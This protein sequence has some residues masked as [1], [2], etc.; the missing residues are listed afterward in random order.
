MPTLR[1]LL[2]VALC[3]PGYAAAVAPAA[4]AVPGPTSTQAAEVTQ[5]SAR[6]LAGL[7]P[8]GAHGREISRTR[9]WGTHAAAMESAWTRKRQRALDP[10][11]G[12]SEREV[13]TLDGSH[14]AL[15][16][17]FSGPDFMYAHTLF[18]R[19]PRYLLVGLEDPGMAPAWHRMDESQAA[20]SLAQLRQSTATLMQLSFFRTNSMKEDFKR[21]QLKGVAPVLMAMAARSGFE[22]RAVDAVHLDDAGSLCLGAADKSGIGGV[23]L[24]L[25]EAGATATRELVYLKVDLSD[26]ALARTPQFERHVRA[27]GAGPVFLKAASYLMHRA[28]FSV[29]RNLVLE[30]ARLVLQDDS[31][32]PYRAYSP[33]EWDRRLYGAYA[34]PI[35]LFKDRQQAALREAYARNAR[36]LD[37]GIGYSHR[38]GTSNLQ[39]FEKRAATV[40]PQQVSM[41]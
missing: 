15:Y 5:A 32:I 29:A 34:K 41:R 26:R 38:A 30:R 13:D 14:G 25:G 24:A 23:R 36:P 20:A 1:I 2:V 18:P 17:P 37:S 35:G 21:G 39:L 31:G 12:F 33:T 27:L 11:R 3:L 28:E 4:C 8:T 6:L 9:F 40:M 22:V 7:A 19:A 16:Y 10:W